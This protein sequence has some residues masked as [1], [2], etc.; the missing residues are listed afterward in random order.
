MEREATWELESTMYNKYPDLFETRKFFVVHVSLSFFG[1]VVEAAE[2][3]D[4]FFLGGDVT[5]K[6][7]D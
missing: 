7:I 4:E 5:Q 1:S 3:D 6:K 2:F